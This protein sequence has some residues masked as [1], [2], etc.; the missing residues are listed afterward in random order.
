[1]RGLMFSQQKGLAELRGQLKA[2]MQMQA[3]AGKRG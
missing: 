2:L 3:A 1:M